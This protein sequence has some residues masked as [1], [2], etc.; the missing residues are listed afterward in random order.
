MKAVTF[1][2][3]HAPLVFETLPDPLAPDWNA[4][5]REQA[6][7][8]GQWWGVLP[9]EDRREFLTSYGVWCARAR[10]LRAGK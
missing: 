9:I 6:L 1:Q 2:A 5:T 7:R 4:M 8:L 3:L 10:Y